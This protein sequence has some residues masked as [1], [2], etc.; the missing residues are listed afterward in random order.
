[1]ARTPKPRKRTALAA[2]AATVAYAG[3][4]LQAARAETSA[5]FEVSA[6]IAPGC[7]VDGL[8]GSGHAGSI[9]TLNFGSDS[10]FST[11]TH[12]ATTTNAQTIRLRCTPG[13]SLMMSIDGGSHAATGARHLQRGVDT[14]A[15]IAY[16]LCRDPTCNLPIT[17]G[18]TSS[19]LVTSVN[20][21]DVRLPIYGSL[22]LPG[23]LPPGTYT[24]TLTV[25]L[26]W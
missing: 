20:S 23:A 5:Q 21:E 17:I 14:G 26:T 19:T 3:G 7:L 4:A 18:G 22:T 11:A 24:D 12:T 16:A 13:V 25:T 2:L 6:E 15:R 1:M 9:G 8:G 10:T